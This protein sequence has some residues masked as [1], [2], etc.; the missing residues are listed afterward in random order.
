MTSSRPVVTLPASQRYVE[1]SFASGSNPMIARTT[2]PENLSFTNL[3]GVIE[4]HIEGTGTLSSIELHS[5]AQTPLC[6][7]GQVVERNGASLLTLESGTTTSR[8]ENIGTTL[9]AGTPTSFYLVVPAATYRHLTVR[10][11]DATGN[12]TERT[13]ASEIVVV[14][15]RIAPLTGL[16][17]EAPIEE[18][19][20]KSRCS[21]IR[22]G[23]S[24]R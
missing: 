4:L 7:R 14:R 24:T 16:R 20:V 1:G 10:M 17:M 23:F 2:A 19:A 15:G 5:D 8:M 12:A 21:K 9:S 18:L 13:A 22:A 11:T 3:C 6:G